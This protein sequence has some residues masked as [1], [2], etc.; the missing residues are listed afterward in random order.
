MGNSPV[1]PCVLCGLPPS[2]LCYPLACTPGVY[3]SGSAEMGHLIPMQMEREFH[4][5]GSS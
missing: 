3:G 4:I 5:A 2:H 1:C